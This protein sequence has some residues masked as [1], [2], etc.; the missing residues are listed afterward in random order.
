MRKLLLLIV[1]IALLL[2]ACG[3]G[4]G[5]SDTTSTTATTSVNES[6]WQCVYNDC[7]EQGGS[8]WQCNTSADM[9]CE[10]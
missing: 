7:L 4:G 6:C 1:V 5:D 8:I 2:T 10:E 3:G 9:A